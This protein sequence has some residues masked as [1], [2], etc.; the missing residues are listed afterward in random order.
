MGQEP[1]AL[2]KARMLARSARLSRVQIRS[3]VEFWAFRA[4][5]WIS[6]IAPTETALIRGENLLMDSFGLT[7]MFARV[8]RSWNPLQHRYW[9]LG[10]LIAVYQLMRS[11]ALI[12]G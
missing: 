7:R 5:A 3:L 8:S 11:Y 10:D 9:R 1:A 6:R 12:I 4:R 2:R